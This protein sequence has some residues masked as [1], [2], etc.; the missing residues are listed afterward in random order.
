MIENQEIKKL[1]N[2]IDTYKRGVLTNQ[3]LHV[4]NVH[5][6]RDMVHVLIG[7]YSKLDNNDG[8]YLTFEKE[9]FLRLLEI[10]KEG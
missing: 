10:R 9:S 8:F 4:K 2:H 6:Q 5:I 7:I 1:N 3:L